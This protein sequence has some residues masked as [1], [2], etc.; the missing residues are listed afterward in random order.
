MR[1]KFEIKR[2]GN[3][4]TLFVNDE[5]LGSVASYREAKEEV[6]AYVWWRDAGKEECTL[7]QPREAHPLAKTGI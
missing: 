4:Y 6:E 5:Y 2:S 7:D 1:D 3:G